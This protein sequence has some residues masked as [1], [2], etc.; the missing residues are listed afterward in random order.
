MLRICDE[1]QKVEGVAKNCTPEPEHTKKKK[2]NDN[3][4][5]K[6][7]SDDVTERDA[8]YR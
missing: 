1:K 7:A 8:L 3:K 2:Q 5:T 4:E 6:T